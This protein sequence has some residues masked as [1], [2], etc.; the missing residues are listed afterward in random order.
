MYDEQIGT[1]YPLGGEK[2]KIS[3]HDMNQVKSI[4]K[5]GITLLGF[6]PR[7]LI[8]PYHNIRTSYF[9]YPDEEHVSGSSQFFD[10]LID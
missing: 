8:K 1:Y 5:P 7:N 4:E 2:V 6:K 3:K 10:G 9:I